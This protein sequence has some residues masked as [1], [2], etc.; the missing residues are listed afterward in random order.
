[1]QYNP[2]TP[3]I[4][5]FFLFIRFPRKMTKIDSEQLSPLVWGPPL[6]HVL[7]TFALSYPLQPNSITKRKYYD[8]IQNLPLFLPNAEIRKSFGALI[9]QY[10]VQPYLKTR[11]SFVHWVHFIHNH[12]NRK[13]GR[14]EITLFEA[15]DR[16]YAQYHTPTAPFSFSQSWKISKGTA[17]N[18]IILG[19]V[20]MVVYLSMRTKQVS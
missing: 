5:L 11:D 2:T 15:L 14:P 1:M 12:V 6:W 8:F 7:F 3:F 4:P 16:Y 19:L 18:L 10:P 17:N 20:G 9:E 13:I